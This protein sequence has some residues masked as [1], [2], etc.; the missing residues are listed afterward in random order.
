MRA[1]MNDG[2]IRL[3]EVELEQN[4]A[5][6][7]KTI[8]VYVLATSMDDAVEGARTTP[9]AKYFDR[10]IGVRMVASTGEYE[11][12][13]GVSHIAVSRS[14]EIDIATKALMRHYA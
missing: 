8:R 4:G 3:Y 14:A 11:K 7:Y 5:L 12:S 9:E 6:S 1:Y 10:A 13:H 2:K